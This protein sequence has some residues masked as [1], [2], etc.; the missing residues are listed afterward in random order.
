MRSLPRTLVQ[1]LALAKSRTLS[2]DGRRAATLGACGSTLGDAALANRVHS[3]HIALARWCDARDKVG[4]TV[5]RQKV[6]VGQEVSGLRQLLVR[7][8]THMIGP[9]T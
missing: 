5:A 7:A 4:L 3:I 8:P 6:E 1:E 2:H 9:L